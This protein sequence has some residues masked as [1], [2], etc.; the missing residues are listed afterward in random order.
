[1]A[2]G[3][4]S[5]SR[6]LQSSGLHAAGTLTRCPPIIFSWL[7][8]VSLSERRTCSEAYGPP[9]TARMAAAAALTAGLKKRPERRMM[10]S[11]LG[12]PAGA[13]TSRLSSAARAL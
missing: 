11:G 8:A 7:L 13:P 6:A 12:V 9:M 5:M 1:M 4:V 10:F 2:A 3:R